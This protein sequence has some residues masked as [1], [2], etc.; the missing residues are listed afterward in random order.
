MTPIKN[1]IYTVK[2]PFP[3]SKDRHYVGSGETPEGQSLES[4][5]P[6]KNKHRHIG[7]KHHPQERTVTEC[8]YDVK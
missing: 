6:Y 1:N 5:R 4:E 3:S 7:T 8:P 2:P